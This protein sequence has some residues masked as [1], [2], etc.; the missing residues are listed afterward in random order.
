MPATRQF[1]DVVF[2]VSPIGGDGSSQRHRSDVLIEYLLEP[3]IHE[4]DP[5]LKVVRADNMAQV[6]DI[7]I[8]II[9]HLLGSRVI[10]A[11]TTGQNPNVYYEIGIAHGRNRPVI[12]LGDDPSKIP[13]D[14]RTQA[15]LILHGMEV[16]EIAQLK[17]RL[18][19]ALEHCL[20]SPGYGGPVEIAKLLMASLDVPT[21]ESAN[22]LRTAVSTLVDGMYRIEK[23]VGGAPSATISGVLPLMGVPFTMNALD[24]AEFLDK[25]DHMLSRSDKNIVGVDVALGRVE[26][27]DR[28]EKGEK[29]RFETPLEL[30]ESG[31]GHTLSRIADHLG[32]PDHLVY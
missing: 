23:L 22:L 11:D 19:R 2:F 16:D 28:N 24:E 7:N 29:V 26:I 6:G 30:G 1:Q 13:F 9:Q 8:G 27:V 32:I 10:V 12:F 4:V 14:V 21:V 5:K 18:R 20:N 15:H 25:L 17:P 31:I 3:V